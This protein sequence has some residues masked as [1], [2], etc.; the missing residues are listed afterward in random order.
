MSAIASTVCDV[1]AVGALCA[2][3]RV[4][5]HDLAM[6]KTRVRFP[7]GALDIATYNWCIQTLVL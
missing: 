3:G 5:T 6:V 7:L 2:Y 4:V 1:Y